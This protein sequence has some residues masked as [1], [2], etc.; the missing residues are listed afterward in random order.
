M[1]KRL[2]HRRLAQQLLKLLIRAAIS[3]GSVQLL[4]DEIA[5]VTLPTGY[6]FFAGPLL[7]L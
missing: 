7:I 6:P 3:P 2:F 4:P 1:F 5:A